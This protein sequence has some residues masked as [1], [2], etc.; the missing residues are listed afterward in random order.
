VCLVRL[1]AL[2][3]Y[4]GCKW[5]YNQMCYILFDPNIFFIFNLKSILSDAATS[6]PEPSSMSS[7]CF[8]PLR[9]ELRTI[10][11]G[12]HFGSGIL[13][14]KVPKT[15]STTTTPMILNR[16]CQTELQ[17]PLMSGFQEQSSELELLSR[18][19]LGLLCLYRFTLPQLH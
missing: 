9:S 7:T 14:L 16:S 4:R 15:F 19:H 13:C 3:F 2:F 6:S 5:S 18:R 12:F 17:T 11:M 8:H 1:Y 10:C